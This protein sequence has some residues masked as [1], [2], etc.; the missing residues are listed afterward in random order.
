MAKGRP[1]ASLT[2]RFSQGLTR[3]QSKVRITMTM[4]DGQ[5]PNDIVRD[6]LDGV[7]EH[8][9]TSW[10][11]YFLDVIAENPPAGN[12]SRT[13]DSLLFR[14]GGTA[15]PG[16]SGLGFFIDNVK[17]TSGLT[18]VFVRT[19]GDDTLCDGTVDAAQTGS[20]ACACSSHR[21]ARR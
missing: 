4:V 15:V 17:L 7:L 1:M 3:F 21:N 8:V 19:D 14:A 13:V 16:T 12:P 18:N 5:V 9:G 11:R 20:G 2:V 6:Y 10:E